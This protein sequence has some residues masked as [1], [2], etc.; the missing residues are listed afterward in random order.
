MKKLP[1]LA[2]SWMVTACAACAPTTYLQSPSIPAEHTI[3]VGGSASLDVLPDEA[4]VELTIAAHDTSML[5]AH[6]SLMSNNGALLAELRQRPGLV[7][8]QGTLGYAPEYEGGRL[9]RYV[10]STQINVRT[11]DFAQIADVIGRAATRG[12]ERVEVVYYSTQILAKKADVRTQALGA[13]REKAQ[14]MA[15]ALGVSLGDV[16][17]IQEGDSRTSSATSTNNYL[18]RGAVDRASNTPAPPGS[19][20]LSSSVSVVYRLR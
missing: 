14:A 5:A 15:G 2:L 18:E 9:T 6:S 8:E 19:I 3:T 13:A 1:R 4:C 12:L 11:R 10:A 7:V 17:T 16:I 20:P